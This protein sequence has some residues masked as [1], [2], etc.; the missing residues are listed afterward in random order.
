M[1]LISLKFPKFDEILEE[2]L[3]SF[4]VSGRALYV[5]VGEGLGQTVA[6]GRPVLLDE[7]RYLTGADRGTFQD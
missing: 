6:L 3:N 5:E 4:P 1:R 7:A 2:T